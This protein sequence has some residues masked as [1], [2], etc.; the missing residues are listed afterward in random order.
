[1]PDNIEMPTTDLNHSELFLNRELSFLAFNRRVLELAKDPAVPLLER[2]KFLCISVTN[3]DEFFEIRVG[4]LK[5]QIALQVAQIGPDGLSPQ[6]Q[7]RRIYEQ[8]YLLVEDQ[9]KALNQE[10][11][12]ALEQENI[13]FVHRA[14]WSPAVARWVGD[15]FL[16]EVLPVLS[17]LGLDPAH[18]FPRLL[19]RSLNFAVT[20]KGEDSFGREANF[21][22]VQ[23]PRSLP[24]LIRLPEELGEGCNDF[25]F[26]SSVI[27]EH[28]DVLFPGMKVSG[29]YQFRVTRNSDLFVDEEEIDDLLSA[30]KGELPSR[31]FGQCV[32]LEVAD[33]CTPE[34]FNYLLEKFAL[35]END[36][37]QV[38]GPV[39]LNRLLPVIDLVDRPDLKYPVLKPAVPQIVSSDANIFEAIKQHN[40]LLHHPYQSFAPVIKFI[41]QAATDPDVLAIKQTLYRTGANSILVDA[42]VDAARTGKEVTVVIEL[43]ARFDEEANIGLADRLHL[44]GCQVVYGIVG[45][46]THAKMA[47]VV[48]REEGVIVRYAHLGTGNYHV[49]KARAYTDFSYLTRDPKITE[50]IHKVF[51][52]LTG[53]GQLNNMQKILEAPFRLHGTIMNLIEKETSNALAGKKAQIMARMNSLIEPQIIHALY[54][55]SQA[56]VQ[57]DLIV[58]GIC[59]LRP[60]LANVSENIRV[61]SILGRFLEHSRVYYFHNAGRSKLFCGSADWMPRNF[62]SRV[63]VVFPIEDSELKKRMIR[64]SLVYYLQDNSQA[65][66]LE[67][68]GHYTRVTHDDS[69]EHAEPFAAQQELLK[70]L[71]KNQS[72]IN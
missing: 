62:F 66:L 64:E 53:L 49:A 21:A 41:R 11:L 24:R 70:E 38:S 48:R 7:L 22:V 26:L 60:G 31:N 42:L 72:N 45:Y 15:Y 69:K 33:K 39:N 29:C 8:A 14:T 61:R 2:L 32:R 47:L 10:I 44:A 71:T 58:R 27:H 40:L 56:G 65:W 59:S 54:K 36:L 43:R 51:L 55:A 34:I 35:A 37:Y 1:M 30:L 19:N 6:E 57:I 3:L 50:D 25:I 5:Q 63:E 46:K 67:A 23:A 52:Q 18:P 20:L 28:V 9:Y 17:P 12:P 68:D 13:R 16:N 4:G